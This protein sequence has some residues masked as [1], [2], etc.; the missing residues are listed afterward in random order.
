MHHREWQSQESHRQQWTL[1]QVLLCRLALR[2][3]M[4]AYCG[5]EQDSEIFLQLFWGS[6]WYSSHVQNCDVGGLGPAGTQGRVQSYL[7]WYKS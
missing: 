3:V 1:L 7:E 5:T 6:P 2:C 4:D